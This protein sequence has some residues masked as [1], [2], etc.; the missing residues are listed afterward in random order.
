[1]VN[2]RYVS[3]VLFLAA[4]FIFGALIAVLCVPVRISTDVKVLNGG[5]HTVDPGTQSGVLARGP[6]DIEIISGKEI[7]LEI[8]L[9]VDPIGRWTPES[10]EIDYSQWKIKDESKDRI[11]SIVPNAKLNWT[12]ENV[13]PF[14]IG[15]ITQGLPTSAT[16]VDRISGKPPIIISVTNDGEFRNATH[17]PSEGVETKS[18]LVFQTLDLPMNVNS[19]IWWGNKF[20]ESSNIE[21]NKSM[22]PAVLDSIFDALKIAALVLAGTFL[23][24]LIGRLLKR[25]LSDPEAGIGLSTFLGFLFLMLSAGSMNYLIKGKFIGLIISVGFVICLLE[26]VSTRNRRIELK[27]DLVSLS[28]Y[29]LVVAIGFLGVASVAT[30]AY[31]N[32][33]IGLAQTDVF[34]YFFGIHSSLNNFYLSG[35]IVTGDGMRSLDFA[36][37][38]IWGFF[39]PDMLAIAVWAITGLFI[40]SIA[41]AEAFS[42]VFNRGLSAFLPGVILLSGAFAGMWTEA[43]MSRWF[44][45]FCALYATAFVAVIGFN[46][47]FMGPVSVFTLFLLTASQLTIVPVFLAVP[48]GTLIALVYVWHRNKNNDISMKSEIKR[49]LEFRSTRFVLIVSGT[50]TAMNLLWLRSI[51]TAVS[52]AG[53]QLNGIVRNIVIPFYSDPEF[54]GT[55]AGILPWHGIAESRRGTPTAAPGANLYDLVIAPVAPYFSYWKPIQFGLTA[56][57]LLVLAIILSRSGPKRVLIARLT[58]L[59][60]LVLLVIFQGS[61]NFLFAGESLYTVLMY[62]VTLSPV[63]YVGAVFAFIFVLS[64]KSSFGLVGRLLSVI[65]TVGIGLAIAINATTVAIEHSRWNDNTQHILGVEAISRAALDNGLES[66]QF[67]KVEPMTDYEYVY[68]VNVLTSRLQDLGIECENCVQQENK[69]SSTVPGVNLTKDDDNAGVI[70]ITGSCLESHEQITNY[71]L[72]TLCGSR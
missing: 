39:L 26:A 50:L 35:D 57:F 30:S 64:N 56:S 14:S 5:W 41:A 66:V 13:N 55:L 52:L 61:L 16:V 6:L 36:S 53:D 42:T 43:Y 48:M 31:S 47:K 29:A 40:A 19:K 63:V 28:P 65:G 1:M 12:G 68:L 45:T 58:P 3:R 60:L 38:S 20:L 72:F 8:A 21:G 32:W 7:G 9:P 25:K 51:G 59:V 54:A 2:K 70:M 67:Q 37:R 18:K 23:S 4:P 22:M 69:I 10:L 33:T 46:A 44:V 15:L 11:T 34:D 27:K 49:V 24:F 17:I 71:E 62:M